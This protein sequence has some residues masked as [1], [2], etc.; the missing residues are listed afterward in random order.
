[1]RLPH[2][3]MLHEAKKQNSSTDSFSLNTND[4]NHCQ[5]KKNRKK[6]FNTYTHFLKH[7]QRKNI[8]PY[9]LWGSMRANIKSNTANINRAQPEIRQSMDFFTKSL[10]IKCLKRSSEN[11]QQFSY[12]H[13]KIFRFDKLE[14]FLKLIFPPCYYLTNHISAKA[15]PTTFK[16]AWQLQE[17]TKH[18]RC[19]WFHQLKKAFIVIYDSVLLPMLFFVETLE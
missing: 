10:F 5:K 8:A 4:S 2:Q 17:N 7:C 3:I 12:A 9:W 19:Y 15:W 13:P 16:S 1:V 14:I 11:M 6:L 18:K